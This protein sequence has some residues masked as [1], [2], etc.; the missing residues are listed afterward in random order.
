MK[1]LLFATIAIGTVF[2]SCSKI[3][4]GGGKRKGEE[5]PTITTEQTISLKP[6][7]R[8]SMSLPIENAHDAYSVITQSTKA[9]KSEIVNYVT[10]NYT[11]PATLPSGITTD[12]VVVSNDHHQFPIEHTEIPGVAKTCGYPQHYIVKIHV[13][14]DGTN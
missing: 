13:E 10:Y 1:K 5:K 2:S 12:E 3:K 14:L 6:G 4:H 8:V 9:V 7:E 11:A